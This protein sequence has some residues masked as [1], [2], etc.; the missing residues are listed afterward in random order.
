MLHKSRAHA[1]SEAS[2]ASRFRNS[3]GATTGT[4]PD[5]N[6]R[7]LSRCELGSPCMD[8]S[9]HCSAR[10][11]RRIP[12]QLSRGSSGPK[13]RRVYDCG[14]LNN[15][16][17]TQVLELRTDVERLFLSKDCFALATEGPTPMSP[18]AVPIAPGHSLDNC[19][20]L[21]ACP[22]PV[23]RCPLRGARL[24]QPAPHAW[25]NPRRTRALAREQGPPQN[26]ATGGMTTKS[27]A[28]RA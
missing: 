23:A 12:L 18:S 24:A 4:R 11:P 17:V 25:R 15:L 20:S 3:P 10:G 14:T 13:A 19:M 6:T 1:R 5:T 21:C 26:S 7:G 22:A 28:P 27:G 8:P 2:S 16:E 9:G